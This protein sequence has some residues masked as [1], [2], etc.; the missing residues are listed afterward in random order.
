MED[1]KRLLKRLTIDKLDDI[2]VCIS[3]K[4]INFMYTIADSVLKD[5]FKGQYEYVGGLQ[6]NYKKDSDMY[7]LLEKELCKLACKILTY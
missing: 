3:N 2:T 6:C 1:I 5:E 4:E 7:N